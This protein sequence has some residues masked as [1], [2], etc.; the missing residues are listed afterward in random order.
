MKTTYTKRQIVEAIAYWE[1]Q[2]KKMNEAASDISNIGERLQDIR[3]L[4]NDG[5][6]SNDEKSDLQ[7]A[8]DVYEEALNGNYV[9]SAQ[10]YNAALTFEH[11]ANDHRFPDDIRDLFMDAH[12][13]LYKKSGRDM[14]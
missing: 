2:L 1:K 11:Y 3:E 6:F 4:V 12:L 8:F 10:A 9:N 5:E 14:R 7:M 13:T